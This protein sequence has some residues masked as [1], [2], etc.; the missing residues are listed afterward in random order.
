[1]SDDLP[2]YHPERKL[3]TR[4]R[5]PGELMWTLRKGSKTLR[6]ELR[7][8]SRS[9][10]GWDMQILEDDDWLSFAQRCPMEASARFLEPV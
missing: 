5:T 10:A 2:F 7:D 8:D 6:C 1:M 9:G 4:T 3:K